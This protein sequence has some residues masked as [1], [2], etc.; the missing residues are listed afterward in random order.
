M[1]EI[2]KRQAT[3][4]DYLAVAA[5]SFGAATIRAVPRA[6]AEESGTDYLYSVHHKRPGWMEVYE[7]YGTSVSK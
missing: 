5:E 1:T 3:I 2:D 6:G 4:G 7:H